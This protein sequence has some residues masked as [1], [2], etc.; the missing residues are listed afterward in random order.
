ME[1][2]L[3]A[4]ITAADQEGRTKQEEGDREAEQAEKGDVSGTQPG[5]KVNL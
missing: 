4:E 5:C 2:V 1:I 3:G